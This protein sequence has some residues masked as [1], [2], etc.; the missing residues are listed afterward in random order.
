VIPRPGVR[1]ALAKARANWFPRDPRT[2]GDDPDYRFS[3]ANERTLLAWIRT[4]LGLMA[5]GLGAITILRDLYGSEV[6]GIVLLVLSFVTSAS[7]YR[8]WALNERA[9]RLAQPLPVSRLPQFLTVG[10]ALVGVI[11]ALLFVLDTW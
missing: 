3:L 1:P 9:M 11:S 5:G 6:L 4:A 2:V 7:S 8:R 10:V